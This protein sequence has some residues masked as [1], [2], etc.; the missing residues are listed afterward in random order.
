[1]LRSTRYTYYHAKEYDDGRV[2]LEPRELRVPA[3]ISRLT[4]GHMDE[5]IRNLSQGEVGDSFELN[6][7]QDLINED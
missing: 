5:A 1:M 4:L 3:S 6:E 7:V 2:L